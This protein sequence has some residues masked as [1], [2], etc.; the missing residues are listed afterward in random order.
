M[1]IST[2]EP[3]TELTRNQ[4]YSCTECESN[5]E[6]LDLDESNNILTFKCNNH[7]IKTLSIKEYFN[8]MEKNTFHFSKCIN[9]NKIQ[10][11]CFDSIFKYCFECKSI[12]C[13]QCIHNHNN[14]HSII[15]NDKLSIKCPF[16]PKNNN[17]NYC[18]ECNVH[19]CQECLF[20]RKHMTHKKINIIEIMPSFEE[21]NSLLKIINEYKT[22]LSK[23][24]I[25]KQN[26]LVDLEVKFNKDKEKIKGDY[27]NIIIH[28]KKNFENELIEN[29]IN[30]ENEIKRIKEKYENKSKEITEKYKL[31]DENNETNFKM[32]LES[33]NNNKENEIYIKTIT[34]NLKDKSFFRVV[35][36]K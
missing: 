13:S 18:L 28:T 34:L 2:L 14:T 29:K 26:I 19:L 25:E 33:L 12:L 27:N 11:N 15:D 36:D 16:H 21:V 32:K 7:G 30:Y 23:S 4:V 1:N 20:L 22:E 3:E 8:N 24:E 6:I 9:C 5:I 35:K 17:Q 10:N 31:I